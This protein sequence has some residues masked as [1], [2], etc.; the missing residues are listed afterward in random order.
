MINKLEMIQFKE[1]A[2]RGLQ[3]SEELWESNQNQLQKINDK[4]SYFSV[5][6]A[7]S[8]QW[9]KH[10]LPE[11]DFVN[12]ASLFFDDKDSLDNKFYK[13]YCHR[14]GEDSLRL[15]MSGLKEFRNEVK[16]II[17]DFLNCTPKDIK[18]FQDKA[19]ER[20]RSMKRQ[21][22]ATGVGRWLFLGS[23]KIILGSEKRFWNDPTIVSIILPSG[24]EVVRG[25]RKAIK[26][27]ISLFQGFRP[28]YLSEEEGSLEGLTTDS[29][30]HSYFKTIADATNSKAIHINSAFYLYGGGYN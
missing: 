5:V 4:A 9:T 28:E 29:I 11:D 17:P 12:R 25:V 27:N 6:L 8:L 24:I 13:K 1:W 14:F 7:I 19:L 26:S 16:K 18:R 23:F 3:F 10:A 2:N 30:I 15:S 20:L 22:K 21:A